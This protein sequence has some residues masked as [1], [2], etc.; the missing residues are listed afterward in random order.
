M[1]KNKIHIVCDVD[2]TIVATHVLWLRY[3]NALVH[4]ENKIGLFELFTSW[5]YRNKNDKIDYN[6]AK[7]FPELTHQEAHSFWAS[8]KLYD[9]AA[10]IDGVI[11]T[12]ASL[13]ERFHVTFTS[14]C[15]IGHKKS[16]KEFIDRGI[17]KHLRCSYSFCDT[18]YKA[19]LKADVVID[20]RVYFLNQFLKDSPETLCILIDTDFQQTDLEGQE[21]EQLRPFDFVAQ[22]WYQIHYY[23][24]DEFGGLFKDSVY[25]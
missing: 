6:L 11:E 13:D 21:I 25:E 1:Q 2:L 12:L 7:Y 15:N 5:K 22:D 19:S 8:D 17:S 18:D 10:V 4:P 14:M 23:L 9:N 16:K 3:L 24:D 20:D